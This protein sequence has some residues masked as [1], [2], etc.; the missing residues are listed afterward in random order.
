MTRPP[1][2]DSRV[3]VGRVAGL[4]GVRGWVKVHADTRPRAGILNYNPW[5]VKLGGEWKVIRVAE[6][7]PHGAG[8]VVRLEGYFYLFRTQRYGEKEQTS[9]YRS[10]DPFDF[11]VDDDRHFVG[12]MP[13]AAPELILHE[14]QWY[15]AALNSKLD[16]IRIAK[17]KWAAIAGR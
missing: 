11:G 4:Y 10:K 6:G 1:A 9:V 17:L 15:I 16:G 3:I 8:I 12:T 7:R 14:N 13:V 2:P 5:Q